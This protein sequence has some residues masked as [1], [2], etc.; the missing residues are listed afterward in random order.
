MPGRGGSSEAYRYGFNGKEK[1]DEGEFGSITNYDYGFR[2]YNPAIGKFLSVDPLTAQYPFYTPYQFAG[3]KPIVAVDLDGLE[4]I[5]IHSAFWTSELLRTD[6]ECMSGE[7]LIAEVLKYNHHYNGAFGGYQDGNSIAHA[8][9]FY[10]SGGNVTS[11]NN[12][13][14][15]LIINGF[16]NATNGD[17]HKFKLYLTIEDFIDE[18]NFTDEGD[19][20]KERIKKK[21]INIVVENADAAVDVAT[22]MGAVFYDR[23]IIIIK[24]GTHEGGAY[25]DENDPKTKR[26]RVV[27]DE[28]GMPSLIREENTMMENMSADEAKS[29]GMDLI[30]KQTKNLTKIP[31]G[32]LPGTVIKKVINKGVK[33]ATESADPNS[34]KNKEKE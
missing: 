33:E 23:M 29:R 17:V 8:T 10:E 9:Q 1:D 28:N 19:D 26:Y 12:P 32:G 7:E 34:K 18:E 15:H 14:G 24:E 30:R 31:G 21:A 11:I 16:T 3:N 27:T 6:L 13:E 4:E 22:S 2:I 25:Y 5:T 20:L